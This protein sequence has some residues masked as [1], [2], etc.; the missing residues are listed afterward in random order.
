MFIELLTRTS[1]HQKS[2][3]PTINGSTPPSGGQR[4]SPAA[5]LPEV[6]HEGT[7]GCTNKDGQED[8]GH[9][10]GVVGVGGC[11][12]REI[13]IYQCMSVC[14]FSKRYFVLGF[15]ASFGHEGVI[16]AVSAPHDAFS[17]RHPAIGDKASNFPFR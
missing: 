4:T 13:G 15:S 9:E 1:T 3:D 16:P 6:S 7:K 2:H 14:A 10:V 12:T 17:S 8:A 5:A 11:R